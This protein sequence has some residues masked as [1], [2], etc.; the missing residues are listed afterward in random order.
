MSNIPF[1]VIN[2]EKITSSEHPGAQGQA[3]W[4]TLQFEQLRVRI[5]EY[6]AGYLADHQRA[7]N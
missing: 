5:V 4:R 6:S 7:I 2:W 3:L 1:Q